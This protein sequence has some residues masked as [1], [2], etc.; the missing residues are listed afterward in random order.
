MNKGFTLIELVVV[1][2]II[3]ILSSILFLSRT[4]EEKKLALQ[5]AA[6]QLSQD[7][8]ETQEM[9]MGAGAVSCV[10]GE[11]H[12]FGVYFNTASSLI[13]YYLFADCDKDQ[14]YIQANDQVL[15][16]VNLEK[17]VQI[18][19]LSPSVSN[20]LNIVFSP[21]NPITFINGREW[22]EEAVI[23][24]SLAG[25]TTQKRVKINSAGRIEIE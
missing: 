2:S 13:S 16:K 14:S 22:G 25:A 5:R 3:V 18:Q 24:F 10:G 19:S 9:A 21:P 12:S 4:G 8:R 1:I 17:G 7:L 11:T 15:R 20:V 6:Y 23:T